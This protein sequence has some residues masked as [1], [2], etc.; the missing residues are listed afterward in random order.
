MKRR[1]QRKQSLKQRPRSVTKR[2]ALSVARQHWQ[3][4]CGALGDAKA[5]EA[6][7][8]KED[9]IFLWESAYYYRLALR[10][11]RKAGWKPGT[12]IPIW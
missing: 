12:R 8:G 5:S 7:S 6:Y 9:P 10:W 3:N 1:N 2:Q 11:F 4:S